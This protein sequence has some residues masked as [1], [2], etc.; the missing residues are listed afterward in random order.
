MFPLN[1]E[2]VGSLSSR[3]ATSPVFGVLGDGVRV[4]GVVG[5]RVVGGVAEEVGEGVAEEVGEGVEVGGGLFGVK[6]AKMLGGKL[7]VGR[8]D[9]LCLARGWGTFGV[10]GIL[11][12][13]FSDLRADLAGEGERSG[14]GL[15]TDSGAEE[16]VTGGRE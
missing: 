14:S 6:L 5:G 11:K 9:F 1:S 15:G 16:E 12:G 10:L 4:A 3:V 7:G 8:I 2:F 13:F